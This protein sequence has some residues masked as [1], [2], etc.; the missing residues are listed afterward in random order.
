MNLPALIEAATERAHSQGALSP[1]QMTQEIVRDG[2]VDFQVEWLSSLAMKDLAA[3]P[4]VGDK[5]AAEFNPFLPYEEALYI[6]DLASA[7][8]AILNKFPGRRGHFLIISRDFVDQAAPLEDGD[9]AASAQALRAAG[10]LFFYN[11]GPVAGASQRHRH[12]QIIPGFRPPIEAVLPHQ[13]FVEPE[14]A[15][16]PFRNIFRRWDLKAGTTEDAAALIEETV[17]AT[18]RAF[19]LIDSAG[20]TAPYNLAMTQDWFLAVP[21]IAEH[22]Q[23]LSISALSV[24]GLMGLRT[25]DQIE[26][27][28]AYRPM[29]M[30]VDVI[31]ANP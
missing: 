26:L 8:V 29:R 25:P 17:A 14:L 23:S 2:G 11:S 9:F 16:L 7:H 5:A 31:G 10:G 24:V 18:Y 20:N 13:G 27:V 21:R 1:L 22:S 28:R 15:P 3:L 19:K 6:A 30:L 4:R 12:M